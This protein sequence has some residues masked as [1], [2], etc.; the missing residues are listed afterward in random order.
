MERDDYLSELMSRLSGVLSKSIEQLE[1][2]MGK[3][4]SDLTYEEKIKFYQDLS[5]L[6]K[7]VCDPLDH[8]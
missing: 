1:K 6:Y 4:F 5:D 2:R 8:K 3:A 7:D